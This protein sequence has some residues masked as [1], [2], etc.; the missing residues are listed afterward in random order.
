MNLPSGEEL[1]VKVLVTGA[2]GFIGYH[3]AERLLREDHEVAGVD[4]FTTYYDVSLKEM[5][6]DQ[7]AARFPD[8]VSHRFL[9]EDC[10]AT[11]R[12]FEEFKPEVVIHL[13]AQAGV[14]YSIEN[15]SAYFEANLGGLFSLMEAARIHKP[16]HFLFAST[17]SVYGNAKVSPFREEAS[18]DRPV[19]LYAA[20]KKSGEVLLHSFA[21]IWD[22][23]TTVFRFFTV[24][25]P[26]GRPDMAP[27]KFVDAISK[28]RTI[29][30]YNHG[31]MRRD[32]TYVGDIVEAIARLMDHLPAADSPRFEGDTVS[33]DAPYRIV[34]IGRGQPVELM[35]FI[36]EIERALGVEANKNF[37]PMQ[38]GDVMETFASTE[39]LRQLTGFEPAVTLREGIGHFVEWYKSAYG[40]SA[41]KMAS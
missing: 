2:A 29:D 17:S 9:L 7:I 35:D 28:G 5:R 33:P 16:R 6:L 36:G 32:F 38:Q 20:T 22:V 27:F 25:G 13:A 21:N 3:M 15:P 30:V 24:Y 12:L 14:R 40:G 39:V 41:R 1:E 8:F 34:N 19:S 10:A 18:T 4:G 31:R 23:P 11:M 37:M 26:W